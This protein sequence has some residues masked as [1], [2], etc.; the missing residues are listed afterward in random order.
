MDSDSESESFEIENINPRA[1]QLELLQLAIEKNIIAF[2]DTGTGKTLIALMLIKEMNGKCI[3][4]A[5]VRILVKQQSAAAAM[6]GIPNM[7][8]IGETAEAW[9]YYDWQTALSKV[10][11]LFMTPELLLNSLRSG[12]LN[13]QQ[14][15]LIVFDECHH[16][17]G[18]HPYMKIMVEFYHTN[19]PNR[20]KILGLTASPVGHGN[21]NHDSLRNDLQNLCNFLDACFVPI[22]RD[23]ISNIAN[24]PKFSVVGVSSGNEIDNYIF[25]SII[26]AIP[27]S[28]DGIA[29]IN[30]YKTNGVEVT[31][32]IGKKA[33]YF[34]LRDSLSRIEDNSLV[35]L[36]TSYE[37]PNDFSDRF[38]KLMEILVDHFKQNGGQVIILTSK[39]ITAWYLSESINYIHSINNSGIKSERLVGKTN[40][41]IEMGLL[42]ISD[43][44]QKE[45]ID[46]FRGKKFNVLV[47]TTVAEEGLDIPACDLVIRY[48]SVSGSLKS[49]VQSKGRARDKNSRF[50]I[51]TLKGGE[52]EIEETLKR[53]DQTLKFLKNVADNE[54]IPKGGIKPLDCYEVPKEDL[55]IYQDTN[56]DSNLDLKGAK[57]SVNWSMDFIESFS[58]SLNK[59]QYDSHK[60]EYTVRHYRPGEC[61]YKV[62]NT[63]G[64]YLAIIKFPNLLGLSEVNSGSI[65]GSEIK[66]KQDAALQAVKFLYEKGYLNRHLRPIWSTR[67]SKSYVEVDYPDLELVDEKGTKLRPRKKIEDSKQTTLLPQDLC[68]YNLTG[69]I[70]S[71]FYVY[72]IRTTPN[73]P[74]DTDILNPGCTM[75]VLIPMRLE[76]CAFNIYPFNLFRYIGI[77]QHSQRHDNCRNCSKFPYRATPELLLVQKFTANELKSIKLF[78][79]ILN[80]ACKSKYNALIT[81]YIEKPNYFNSSETPVCFLPIESNAINFEMINKTIEFFLNDCTGTPNPLLEPYPGCIV[82]S[83]HL[84]EFYVHLRAIPDGL[85]YEFEDKNYITTIKYYYLNK[86]GIQLTSSQ[87]AEVRSLGKF[88]Q[89]IRPKVTPEKRTETLYLPIELCEVCPVPAS[90][91]LWCRISPSIF[92]KLNQCFLTTALRTIIK[93]P[94][95]H[96]VL[97]EAITCGSSL[98]GIDYQRL[99]ILGD[100]ILKFVTSEFLFYA[101]P[102]AFEGVLTQKRTELNSNNNLFKI[103]VELKVYRYM[104]AKVFNVKHWSPQGLVKVIPES[105]LEDPDFSDE[106]LEE[107]YDEIGWDKILEENG[108]V[109]I[110]PRKQELEISNKQLADCIEALIGAAYVQGG[111]ELAIDLSKTL[112]ILRDFSLEYQTTQNKKNFEMLEQKLEYEFNNPMILEE[113][114][115]HN[116]TKK[117]FDYN[118]LEFL[119]DALIDFV[120]LDYFFNKFKYAG[121]GSIS[122][123]KATAVSNRTFSYVSYKLGLQDH[124]E[125]A[126][127]ELKSDLIKFKNNIDRLG[128]AQNLSKLPDPGIKVMADLFESVMAAI[129]VD[130]KDLELCKKLIINLL[131]PVIGHLTPENCSVHPHNRLFD[132]AQ[133]YKKTLGSIKIERFKLEKRSGAE[134]IT[135]IYVQD[136]LSVEGR[137]P[138][139]LSSSEAAADN[140]F[141]KYSSK[142]LS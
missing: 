119:G 33:F 102:N 19:S 111:I 110:E 96:E 20:P 130:S 70:N 38:N 1:Y 93:V 14:F 26:K 87:I 97:I 134:F 55:L 31:N 63:R 103:A 11:C 136:K 91:L 108:Q 48:D 89:V 101:Y 16:C 51:L 107:F 39:R 90:L 68:I 41:K 117:S 142:D 27:A 92:H 17:N 34:L 85:N 8:I 37:I 29:L 28:D 141:L 129:Y 109:K 58:K 72:A 9:D 78:H 25:S 60:I 121:P 40:R 52:R 7:F 24:E 62:S 42:R 127:S 15:K 53:F 83:K 81:A 104:Q 61:N 47:S 138:S 94:I 36:L 5:P 74:K 64:G 128:G 124:L 76:I 21:I 59:S 106:E 56:L 105:E 98:E 125:Y 73:Y 135:K 123:M 32:L 4:L 2:L 44:R 86:Y 82:K 95:N 115:T 80:A 13:L 22:D 3:F 43:L 30:L 45:I 88:R 46:A 71:E 137:G 131:S 126:G 84:K 122:K 113:A 69:S 66:A 79:L 49:Y 18:N 100:S 118:R 133:K 6:F 112:G 67:P 65:H 139:K 50:I 77:Q 35:E 12:Y 99:E 120:I 75:G 10:Q 140:F 23:A 116:S 57:V 114:L 54:I 132:F